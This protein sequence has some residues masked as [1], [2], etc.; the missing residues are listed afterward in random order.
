MSI[1]RTA[2]ESFEL[3][4]L[5]CVELT[6]RFGLDRV[7]RMLVEP[8]GGEDGSLLTVGP[9]SRHYEVQVKGV[10]G[11]IGLADLALWLTHFPE[12]KAQDMLIERLVADT[13][14]HLILVISGR[15]SD[16]LSPLVAP[17]GWTG[18]DLATPPAALSADLLS[19]FRV[20]DVD[21]QAKKKLRIDRVS[22]HTSVASAM[23]AADIAAVLRRTVIIERAVLGE[24]RDRIG[25]YLANQAI[26]SDVLP[27]ATARLRAIV[28]LKRK[29]GDDVAAA[30][31][32]QIEREAPTTVKPRDYVRGD[33]EAAWIDLV[34]TENCLLLSGVTRSGKSVAAR[35]VAAEFERH[36]TRVEEFVAVEAAE[37]FLLGATHGAR[38]AIV[39]DPLGGVHAA[40][41]PDRQLHRLAALI[42][43]LDARRRLIVA[44]GRERLLEVARVAALADASING[45]SWIDTAKRPATFLADLWRSFADRS[46]VLE[47]LRSA[48]GKAVEEKVVQLEPGSLEYLANLPEALPGTWSVTQAARAAMIDAATLSRALASEAGA[49]TLLPALAIASAAREPLAQEELAFVTDLGGNN[50]PSKSTY[51]GL[52]RSIGGEPRIPAPLPAYEGSI[53]LS[54]AM[55]DDLDTLERRRMIATDADR[56]FGFTHPF[57]R[58]AAELLLRDPTRRAADNM[59]AIHE[60]ALFS[61]APR[62]SRAAARNLDWLLDYTEKHP[63]LSDALFR[64]AEAGLQSLFPTTRDLCFEF[65]LRNFDRAERVLDE[66][67]AHAANSVASIDLESL[68]WFGGQAMLPVDGRIR[69]DAMWRGWFPP[70]TEAIAPALAALAAG[71]TALTPEAAADTL[72]YLKDRPGAATPEHVSSLLAYDEGVIRAEAARMWLSRKRTN[73]ELI[74]QRIFADSH[75][76]VARRALSGC[77]AGYAK[78]GARRRARLI[79]GLATMAVAPSNA[80][81]FLQRLVLFDRAPSEPNDRPWAVFARLMPVVLENIP[82][83]AS[84]IEARLHHVMIDAGGHLSADELA[85]ICDR[86][87][88]WIERMD[89]A[90]RPLSD[91]ALGVSVILF[92]FLGD[93]PELRGDMVARLLSL[94]LTGSL[95]TVIKDA[96]DLWPEL[97]RDERR[98]LVQCLTSD[99]ADARW[100]KAVA[101]TRSEVPLEI[102]EALLPSGV[103]LSNGQ[104]AI[105]ATVPTE[106]FAACM[107]IA[108]GHP[109]RLAEFRASPQAPIWHEAIHAIARQPADP[110]FDAAFALVAAS[111][112]RTDPG[113]IDCLTEAARL[114]PDSVFEH[115]LQRSI[116]DGGLAHAEHWQALLRI[117]PTGGDLSRW[118]DRLA[119]VAHEVIYK[120][121]D[122]KKWLV[123]PDHAKQIDARLKSDLD[124]YRMLVV[125]LEFRD[126][127]EEFQ[128]LSD[129]IKANSHDDCDDGDVVDESNIFIVL[130]G[131]AKLVVRIIHEKPPHFLHT[132]DDAR[133]VLKR[134]SLLTDDH[135]QELAAT[136]ERLISTHAAAGDA[137]ANAD[138]A[139][140]PADWIIPL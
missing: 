138:R 97:S 139:K 74:L 93:R 118:Y 129:R 80:S 63:G 107:G 126:K 123:D 61:R 38:I 30:I 45:K 83:G 28:G 137:Y 131:I 96:V 10:A 16:A 109:D 113:F 65:I 78:C 122:I 9:D 44:Q 102:E 25:R 115:L 31:A 56:R 84:F 23:T 110:L 20:S 35:F 86:W 32:A 40:V 127:V 21:G 5:V 108:C 134:H 77:I 60:R 105:R 124:V 59:L 100:R 70:N 67:I 116:Y 18:A 27:D 12:R 75:P 101:L 73:D 42:P 128:K 117:G 114:N 47:P 69:D 87:V 22:H 43:R 50:L 7:D 37:R 34:R 33:E 132:V 36:G 125:F 58:A 53:S 6:L 3:Q 66:G 89:A 1:A 98:A 55:Q 71:G 39:D 99:T 133:D 106:L 140:R 135:A 62:T 120:A 76:L 82:L 57:Y 121:T 41:D 85:S 136:R 95:L 11:T 29:G 64:R 90:E 81:L 119:S 52:M 112:E 8:N 14:R 4:D 2:P 48:M 94:R 49:Q 103:R 54:A 13:A 46:G 130:E 79:D 24:V 91:Y 15:A 26:P 72:L 17:Q 104:K 68:D 88:G 111:A 51:L 19:A 92:R